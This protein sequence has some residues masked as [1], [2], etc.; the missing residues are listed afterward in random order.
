[1]RLEVVDVL[2]FTADNIFVT[3]MVREQRRPPV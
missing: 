1:M 2:I 3:V